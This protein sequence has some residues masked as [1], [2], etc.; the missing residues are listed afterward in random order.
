MQD[1]GQDVFRKSVEFVSKWVHPWAHIKARRS[2]LARET[3]SGM[4]PPTS[5]APNLRCSA[6]LTQHACTFKRLSKLS[7]RHQCRDQIFFAASAQCHIF[8]FSPLSV[9]YQVNPVVDVPENRRAYRCRCQENCCSRDL[10]GFRP[11]VLHLCCCS[12]R[13]LECW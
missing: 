6:L 10:G 2:L 13:S 3:I 5:H 12:L 7:R 9:L 8:A 4:Q 1:Q 11:P